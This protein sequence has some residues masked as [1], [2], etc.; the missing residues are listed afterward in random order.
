MYYSPPPGGDQDTLTS[1]LWSSPVFHLLYSL[2][3][4]AKLL[5]SKKN[6]NKL[7][8]NARRGN[9]NYSFKLYCIT[10]LKVCMVPACLKSFGEPY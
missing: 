7:V 9:I 10:E 5:F 1:L 2:W 6:Y 3:V 8:L 4:S